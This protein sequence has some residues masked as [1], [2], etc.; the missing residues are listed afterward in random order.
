MAIM[1]MT[2][3]AMNTNG[4]HCRGTSLNNARKPLPMASPTHSNG[5][6]MILAIVADIA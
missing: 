3:T 2:M 4:C 5:C 1:I 6:A